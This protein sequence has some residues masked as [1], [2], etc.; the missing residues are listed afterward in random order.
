MLQKDILPIT[1]FEDNITTIDFDLL[2]N[3]IRAESLLPGNEG[4]SLWEGGVKG[5]FSRNSKLLEVS[6]IHQEII[7]RVIQITDTHY[8]YKRY[9][10]MKYN[11]EVWWNYYAEGKFQEFHSHNVNALSGIVYLTDSDAATCFCERGDR[12]SVYPKKG[13]IVIF[14]SWLGHYV[15]PAK[16]ERC[17]V[18]FNFNFHN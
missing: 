7:K 9:S 1:I 12:H 18:A 14:P 4:A 5:S 13:K 11:Y 6:G 17:T 16:E 8:D 2:L 15:Q 3:D 10:G